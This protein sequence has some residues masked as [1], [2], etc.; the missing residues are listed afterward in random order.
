MTVDELKRTGWIIMDAVVGS[1]AFGLATETSDVDT[2]GVFVLPIEDRLS[3]NA[4]D[5]VADEKNNHVYWE[6]KKF[7]QLL[8][9]GNPSALE[10]LNSPKRCILQGEEFFEMIPKDVWITPACCKSFLEYAKSQLSRA[11]GLNKKI[12]NP[13]PEEPPKVLDYCYVVDGNLAVPFKEWVKKRPYECKDEPKYYA[14]AAIDHVTDTYALYWENVPLDRCEIAAD[15]HEWRWAYGVVSDEDKANDI[16]L[17]SIPK[18]IPQVGILFFNKNAYSHDCAEHTKYWKWV[19][20]RNESRYEETIKHGQGYDAK[21]TM[22]CIRLLM[23]AKDI[24]E[25]GTVTVDRTADREYLLSI[26]QG[27]FTYEEMMDQS[28]K[29]V[30]EVTEAFKNSTF[31]KP[32]ISYEELDQLFTSLLLSLHDKY[33]RLIKSNMEFD[34]EEI[35]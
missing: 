1:Q 31:L 35:E 19:K 18:G 33:N 30:A 14:I 8:R 25:R 12:F 5:Q 34:E 2:R 32:V 6:L 28:D 16:Q 17:S 23:T 15:E 13:Q 22:H 11:Y 3:Y 27:K 7:L 9:D 20:D 29:L 10:L 26:K 21:N 24:A 4:I